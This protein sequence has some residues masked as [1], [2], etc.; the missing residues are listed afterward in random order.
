MMRHPMTWLLVVLVIPAA[1]QAQQR[2]DLVIHGGTIFTADHQLSIHSAMAVHE[3]RVVALGGD[4]LRRRYTG[5]REV[6]LGGRFVV[7]GFHD[8]HTHVRG[9]A[10]RYVDME[11]VSSLAEFQARLRRKAEELGP[12]EWITGYGWAEDEMMERRIPT[13]H[14]LDAA[15]PG[16]PAI[17]SRAGGHSAVLNSL[18]L[19]L[20]GI[21]A[22]TADPAGGTIERDSRGVPTGI[23]LENWG[24]ASRLVPPP[25]DAEIRTSLLENLRAQFA[26]GITSLIQA[27]ASPQVFHMWRDLYHEHGTGLPRAAVQILLPVGFGEGE[28]AAARLRQ[29]ELRTGQGD[30]RLRVGALKLFID[31][32]YTGPAAWTREPYPD[33]PT[34]TGHP[35]LSAQDLYDVARQA[36]EL[37][38]QMGIHAIGDAAIEMAVDQLVRVLSEAP[39]NDH[40]HY[41]NHFTVLPPSRTMQLMADHNI[42]IAQ[43]PNFTWTLEGRYA[44]HL[45]PARAQTNNAL[46][47]PMSYGILVALGADILP[48]GP[49]FGIFAAVTRQGMSGTVVGEGERLTVPEALVGYTRTGAY[50]TFEEDVKGTLEPGRYADFVVLSDD[51][52]RIPAARIREARV[53]ETWIAGD[54]VY[55]APTGERNE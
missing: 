14:D 19:D 2:V 49:L 29:M 38:W 8:T 23:I 46:R 24:M 43:Q 30:H 47:T 16:N 50:L 26:H 44:R 28:A 7:P 41:L 5:E 45:T 25:T 9:F 37:G 3:G 40:R 36:H 15:I 18:A 31:G 35:R 42:H 53:L 33:N 54:R 10:R 51:L 21:D 39:R 34:Y 55:R 13:R 32:G 6:D 11:G 27:T 12:G 52:R 48:T 4:D 17:I 1:L 20:A 22:A